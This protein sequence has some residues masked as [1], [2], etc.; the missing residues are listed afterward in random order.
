[1]NWILSIPYVT[2]LVFSFKLYNID[3]KGLAIGVTLGLLLFGVG[4]FIRSIVL[5]FKRDYSKQVKNA[6]LNRMLFIKIGTVPFFVLNF[7]LWMSILGLVMIFP[8]GIF[9]IIFI[10]LL[11]GMT[12]M[13]L[14]V[15]S[16]STFSVLIYCYKA[17]KISLAMFILHLIMQLIFVV[18]V[19]SSVY[20]YIKLR[21]LKEVD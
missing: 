8:G 7:L 17:K 1:M 6:M 11:V 19:F 5:A 14:I 20:L 3:S 13:V 10:P 2:L 4:N 15:T 18:D 21:Q 9:S 12:Y 16:S